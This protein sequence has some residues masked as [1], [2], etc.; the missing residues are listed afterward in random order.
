MR[1]VFIGQKGIPARFGGVEAHVD[2]LARRLAVR[3][4]DVGVYVRS[5]Y[6]PKAV[7]TAGKARLIH[8]PTI[9][10]KH[11]DASLHGFLCALH[12]SAGG[13]DLVHFHGIGPSAFAFVPRLFGKKVVA[14][15]HR[16]D[17]QTE[18]WGPAARAMLRLGEWITVRASH[19]TIV[20]SRDLQA[21]IRKTYGRVPIHIPNGFEPP[22]PAPAR[23]ITEKYGLEKNAYVLFLG[24][25]APEKRVEWLI[26]AFAAGGL[27]T[28]A[29]GPLRLVI[30]GGSSATDAYVE[31]LRHEAAGRRD[32]L[33]TGYVWGAEKEELIANTRL[34][35]LPSSLEGHPV[36]LLEARSRG[37]CCLASDIPP[38][39][40]AIRDG[41]DGLLFAAGD[42]EDLRAKLQGALAD[43]GR[44]DRI[45]RAAR[46]ELRSRP[47]WDAVAD[48]TL[49]DYRELL[50]G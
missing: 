15:I 19:R 35:V 8:V 30:A 26:R 17:W 48:R 29:G 23:L 11:L 10:Q 21:Y 37:V 44:L 1:V 22:E 13:A 4:V 5:W 12:A 38:H 40:E 7:R 18:K 27:G 6:T 50:E 32:I 20:V 14:T 2:A 41:R 34:L 33:F 3:G 36:V 47:D 9:H 16:L 39:R 24:R 25:L 43:P 49:A 42:Y 45:G 31:R 46:D 28:P